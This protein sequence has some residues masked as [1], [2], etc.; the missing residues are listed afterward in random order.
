MISIRINYLDLPDSFQNIDLVFHTP[1]CLCQKTINNNS[2]SHAFNDYVILSD[3]LG[4][5]ILLYLKTMTI[6]NNF[7]NILQ[8]LS[9]NL[10]HSQQNF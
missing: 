2:I 6:L 7:G 4:N 5:V 1:C 9:V 3:K 8:S 10:K